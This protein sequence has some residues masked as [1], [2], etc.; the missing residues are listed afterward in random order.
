M[1]RGLRAGLPHPQAASV[2]GEG[3]IDIHCFGSLIAFLLISIHFAG[4]LSQ[5]APP[6]P[7]EGVALY[8]VMVG[9]VLTGL[10]QR[11]GTASNAKVRHYTPRFNR[12]F[13]VSLITASYIIL[14]VHAASNVRLG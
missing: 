4:Q 6:D 12:A 10:M 1:G 3:L 11:F 7:G 14:V 2:P 5:T 8:I 9:L 13:R